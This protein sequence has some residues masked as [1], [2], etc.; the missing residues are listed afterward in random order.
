MASA[1][2]PPVAA[3]DP[4][5]LFDVQLP[6]PAGYDDRSSTA[7]CC[8]SPRCSRPI[9]TGSPPKRRADVHRDADWHRSVHVWL[10]DVERRV[11]LMQKRSLGKDTFPG[12]WDISAAGHIEAGREAC[13]TAARECEE[14]L[15][16]SLDAATLADDFIGCVPAPMAA[17]GGCNAYEEIFLVEW[18]ASSSESFVLGK[19]EVC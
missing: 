9:G 13:E 10:L 8:W 15:G 11:V 16:I 5:E 1:P 3:Q 12:R 2:P 18:S 19:A 17:R 7:S 4:G 6:P 14:E